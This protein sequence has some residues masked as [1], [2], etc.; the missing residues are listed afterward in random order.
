MTLR[1]DLD[2]PL[3]N[4]HYAPRVPLPIPDASIDA[5]PSVKVTINRLWFGHIIGMLEALDQPDAWQGTE[6]EIETARAQIRELIASAEEEETVNLLPLGLVIPFAGLTATLPDW[7]LLCDGAVHD[8]VDY[9][10]L[11]AVLE[12]AFVIDADTFKTPDL[13]DR[14]VSGASSGVGAVGGSATETLTTAQMPVHDHKKWDGGSNEY[15]V[16]DVGPPGQLAN[17]TFP[18]N[19]GAPV[20]LVPRTGSAGSGAAHNN[21]P[22]YLKLRY[23][24]VAKQS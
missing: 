9:P 19:G 14:F 24:I 12:S 16:M 15:V 11:Y 10:D 22:P 3:V 17:T 4:P 5:S 23:Y 21:L 2:A 1:H 18:N 7:L 20:Y 6:Y 13:N 8:R